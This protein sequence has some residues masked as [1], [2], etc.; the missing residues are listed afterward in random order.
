[1]ERRIVYYKC[2]YVRESSRVESD[3]SAAGFILSLMRSR[4]VLFSITDGFYLVD[5]RIAFWSL[6]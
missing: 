2:T 1:M 4:S 6:E 5:D 3:D